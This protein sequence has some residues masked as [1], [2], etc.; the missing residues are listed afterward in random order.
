MEAL[1]DELKVSGFSCSIHG[2]YLGCLLYAD[3]IILLSQSILTMQKMLDICTEYG[4]EFDIRFNASKSVA[5]RIGSGCCKLA[6]PL[7][8]AHHEL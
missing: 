8:L 3:D 7:I 5:M 4:C 1:I 2:A 6:D